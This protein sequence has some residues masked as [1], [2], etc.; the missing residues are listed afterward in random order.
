MVYGYRM[1]MVI[2]CVGAQCCMGCVAL[3]KLRASLCDSC[4][5]FMLYGSGALLAHV[6][7]PYM[8]LCCDDCYA[9]LGLIRS[10]STCFDIIG[11][12][13]C[14]QIEDLFTALEAKGGLTVRA[15]LH[16]AQLILCLLRLTCRLTALK[17]VTNF[18]TYSPDW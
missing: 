5:A 6:E 18:L 12:S 9:Y 10:L 13:V 3:H 15:R 7:L 16:L 17:R 1:W 14:G 8:T 11:H 4:K 2:G